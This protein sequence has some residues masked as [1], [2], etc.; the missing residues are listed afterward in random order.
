MAINNKPFFLICLFFWKINGQKGLP[1]R[2]KTRN[3]SII[4]CKVLIDT[5]SYD[6][7]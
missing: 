6:T 2:I 3:K 1:A 5:T 4:E 7:T